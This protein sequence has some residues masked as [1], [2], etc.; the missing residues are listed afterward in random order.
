MNSSEYTKVLL[1]LFVC[2]E[3]VLENFG[4]AFE[5][6]SLPEHYLAYTTESEK[7]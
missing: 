2:H 6:F 4:M 1:I 7:T 5:A 3:K